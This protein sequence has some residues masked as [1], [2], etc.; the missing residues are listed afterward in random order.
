MQNGGKITDA[1]QAFTNSEEYKVQSLYKELLNRQ[2]DEAGIAYW[3]KLVQNGTNI[4][5]VSNGIKQS[6]EYKKLHAFADGINYVPEDMD[7]RIHEGERILPKA[8]NR[9]LM[10]ALRSPASNNDVLARELRELRREV[11]ELRLSNTAE[12]TAI[13]RDGAVVATK[14]KRW[15]GVNGLRLS[16]DT[17][18]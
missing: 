12:N 4:S 3:T 14:M 2:G 13:Q 16:E 6:E 18:V 10:S 15:D 9:E 8:D 17:T 5:D 1:A 7:A 11:V